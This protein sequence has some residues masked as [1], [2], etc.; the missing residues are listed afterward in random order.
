M[1]FEGKIDLENRQIELVIP[2]P[3]KIT[4]DPATA[5]FPLAKD[6]FLPVSFDREASGQNF[7]VAIL[8]RISA[9]DYHLSLAV[10]HLK[11]PKFDLSSKIESSLAVRQGIDNI[12]R[13]LLGKIWS[14]YSLV[15]YKPID[16][17][18]GEFQIQDTYVQLKS[19]SFGNIQCQ[20]DIQLVFPFKVDLNVRLNGVEINDFL[21][22][23]V[24]RKKFEAS[25]FISGEINVQGTF[26]ELFLKGNLESYNG[27]VHQLY[28]DHMFLSAEGFYPNIEIARLTISE[29][30]GL[31]F[32]LN[33]PINLRDQGNFKK[34]IQALNSSPLVD[35][36]GSQREWTIKRLQE[37]KDAAATE[38]KYLLRK[39]SQ[40]TSETSDMLGV[41]RKVEF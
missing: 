9:E 16:E 13:Y 41:E 6:F 24:T 26:N 39:E 30:D 12:N 1:S 33:G 23:W 32:I 20:G 10:E 15:D 17:F 34:Q 21:E 25:G 7:F 29:K 19:F 40:G 28:Y 27:F 3:P 22:F 4:E 36:S 35:D 37:Q 11:T 38:F 18:K 14:Q 31:S 2:E 5:I 8:Q